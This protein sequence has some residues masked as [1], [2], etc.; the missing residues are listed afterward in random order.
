MRRSYRGFTLI[1]LLVV[2]AI[3]AILA[4]I[5]FPVFAQAREKA[6]QTSCLSNLKQ[7]AT[8]V[9]MYTQDYD[10]TF[11]LSLYLGLNGATPCSFTF[12]HGV[13]PYQKNGDIMRCPSHKPELNG[14]IGVQQAGM[15]P[16]CPSNPAAIL[17]SYP[18]NFIVVEQ[19]YPN[20]VFGGT[21]GDSRRTAR[22]LA[23]I[24]FPAETALIYDGNITHQG[25]SANFRVF[26]SP[27]EPRHSETL[28]ANYTDGHAKNVKSRKDMSCGTQC[29]GPR[30]DRQANVRV[31]K[32]SEQGPY[33]NCKQLFGLAGVDAA[34]NKIPTY[35]DG[36]RVN[37]AP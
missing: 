12:Y 27:I 20:L 11:P 17:L 29:E 34:G 25:G 6:R 10:E 23:A 8:A 24:D 32:V 26:D 19:G 14:N 37:C 18:F 9:L 31:W 5:L 4:A 16:L 21:A 1:E 36:S 15:P 2:I 28:N 30:L 7:A 3:I 33:V 13:A 22:S 35:G